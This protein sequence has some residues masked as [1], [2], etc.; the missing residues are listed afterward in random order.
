ME[1]LKGLVEEKAYPALRNQ[2]FLGDS[3]LWEGDPKNRCFSSRL[4]HCRNSYWCAWGML[5]CSEPA[6][7]NSSD[8]GNF[9]DGELC[10]I[11][12]ERVFV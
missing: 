7:M 9:D 3:R 11:F 10:P 5:F 12:R 6:K 4:S 2:R 1:V 8:I